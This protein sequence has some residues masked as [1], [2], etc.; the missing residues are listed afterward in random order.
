MFSKIISL[1]LRVGPAERKNLSLMDP[2][3][4][5]ETIR[6]GFRNEILELELRFF[7]G[8]ILTSVIIFSL[9]QLGQVFMAFSQGFEN[10]VTF[11][12]VGFGVSAILAGL[13]LYF[14]FVR[15]RPWGQDPPPGLPESQELSIDPPVLV[16]KFIEGLVVGFGAPR[17]K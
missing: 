7:L 16:A 11:L 9:I 5:I 3:G 8:T 17:R 4:V 6:Q 2:A 1:A 15:R 14:M 10:E 13:G 12:F